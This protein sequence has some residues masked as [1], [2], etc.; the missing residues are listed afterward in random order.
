MWHPETGM[1][2]FTLNNKLMIEN[3]KTRE[4]T[5][6]ANATV[7]LSCLAASRCGKYIAVGEGSQN[8]EGNSVVLVYEIEKRRLPMRL[9][10]H[11]K[12]I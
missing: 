5:L 8:K 4:Q 10:F 2:F 11:Q 9:T 3:T 6:M 12:G 1:T 7:Q